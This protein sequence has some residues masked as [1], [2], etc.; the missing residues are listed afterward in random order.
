MHH[1]TAGW[2]LRRALWVHGIDSPLAYVRLTPEYSLEGRVRQIKC[3]TLICRAAADE[4]GVTARRLYDGL[5][6]DKA[7][8][9]FTRAE[10][11]GAHCEAGARSVFNERAF[12]WLDAAL[13]R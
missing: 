10:G 11:A 1:P 5:V 8:I 9:E 2:A 7:F 3:P 12:D 4:I 13:K 6:C